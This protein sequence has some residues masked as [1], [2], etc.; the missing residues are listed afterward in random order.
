MLAAPMLYVLLKSGVALLT[1]AGTIST[2]ADN[3]KTSQVN[4]KDL[5]QSAAASQILLAVLVLFNSHVQIITRISSGSPLWYWWLADTL[6][7]HKSKETANRLVIYM[8]MY[9]SIQ[10]SLFASFLP[11]A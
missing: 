4:L 10:G 6:M 9:A 3:T 11:P 1:S 5:V 2:I 7:S 8:I